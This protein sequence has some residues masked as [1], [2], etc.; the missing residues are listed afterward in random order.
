MESDDLKQ[1]MESGK[2][3]SDHMLKDSALD[4]YLRGTIGQHYWVAA[5][6]I[7]VLV[8]VVLILLW[9]S[10]SAPAAPADS[11]SANDSMI[12]QERTDAGYDP[13]DGG[14]E[15]GKLA[16]PLDPASLSWQILHSKDYDCANRK[17]VRVDAWQWMTDAAKA[18]E[19][20][21]ST[22]NPDDNTLSAVMAGH[23]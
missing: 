2:T 13:M 22:R 18:P 15:R 4:K 21:N 19:S 5:S 7:A 12:F 23:A 10:M 3:S 20:F 1:Y 17:P 14:N 16:V 11:F 8:V 9:R 6:I